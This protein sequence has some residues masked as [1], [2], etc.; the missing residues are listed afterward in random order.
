[1]PEKTTEGTEMLAPCSPCLR[2]PSVLQTP[3]PTVS[4]ETLWLIVSGPA[5]QFSR[6]PPGGHGIALRVGNRVGKVNGIGAIG[7]VSRGELALNGPL[8]TVQSFS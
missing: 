3:G 2:G 1:M 8:A 6:H 4:W 5:P 7:S